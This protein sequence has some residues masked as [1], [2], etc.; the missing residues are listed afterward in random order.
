MAIQQG[1]ASQL[2]RLVVGH[3]LHAGTCCLYEHVY[4]HNSVL[5]HWYIWGFNGHFLLACMG[6]E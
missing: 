4:G 5:N 1:A 3:R 6:M 2:R